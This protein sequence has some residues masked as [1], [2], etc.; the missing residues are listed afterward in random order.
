[1]EEGSFKG[2]PQVAQVAIQQAK[3]LA[4]NFRNILTNDPLEA[5]AYRDLGSMATIG[6]NHAV[7]DLPFIKFQG[8]FAWIVWLF[9]HLFSIIGVKNKIFIF[10]NWV[11]NYFTFDQSLRLIIKPRKKA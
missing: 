2:H 11:W 4:Y 7:V 10:L 8:F 1:L 5:F 9:V 3:Q 6:R